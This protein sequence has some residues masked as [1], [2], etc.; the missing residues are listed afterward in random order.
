MFVALVH[1]HGLV[2]KVAMPETDSSS[3][4]GP[5]NAILSTLLRQGARDLRAVAPQGVEAMRACKEQLLATVHR[6]LSIHLGTPPERF[7]W[8]WTDKDQASTAR[9]G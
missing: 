2:P 9:A 1:K 7:L 8:Q 4:T 3:N 6:M 5:M